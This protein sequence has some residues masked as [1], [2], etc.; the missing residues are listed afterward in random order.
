MISF[1]NKLHISNKRP[2]LITSPIAY[3]RRPG[4]PPVSIPIR[5]GNAS[6]SI[7]ILT[8]I[9][10]AKGTPQI[11]NNIVTEVIVTAMMFA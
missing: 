10:F 2:N 7:K 5:I 3:S 9:S 8:T 4:T 1:T 6:G 11:D